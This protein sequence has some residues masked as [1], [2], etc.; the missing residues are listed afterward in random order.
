[1]N[2]GVAPYSPYTHGGDVL[3]VEI[4]KYFLKKYSETEEINLLIPMGVSHRCSHN[5]SIKCDC[6]KIRLPFAN[7]VKNKWQNKWQLCYNYLTFRRKC[8]KIGHNSN[9]LGGRNVNTYGSRLFRQ[10]S[11]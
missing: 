5:F 2:S 3:I 10:T 4:K 9:E 7:R 8:R 1:M 6:D 11:S